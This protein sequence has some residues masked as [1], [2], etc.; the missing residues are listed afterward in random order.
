[1]PSPPP[2]PS[3]ASSRSASPTPTL[4]DPP[5]PTRRSR[6]ARNALYLDKSSLHKQSLSPASSP[7]YSGQH[8]PRSPL[9]PTT[10]IASSR[11]TSDSLDSIWDIDFERHWE[12][13][14]REEAIR[15]A[16]LKGTVPYLT[17]GRYEEEMERVRKE[18][19]ASRHVH[20]FS[21]NGS[22]VSRGPSAIGKAEEIG[23]GSSDSGTSSAGIRE[24]KKKGMLE[25][26]ADNR[27]TL[28]KLMRKKRFHLIMIGLVAFDLV[29][30]MIELIVA[31]LTAG[32]VNEEIYEL[33]LES[34]KHAHDQHLTPAMF[35]CSLAPSHSREMLEN[36]IFGVNL[37]LLSIFTLDVMF[38][39]Y[40][41]GPITYATSW[42]TLLDGFVVLT[43]FV[44][45]VYFHFSKDPNAESPIALVILRLWKIFRAAHAIGHA[46][47]L[48]Y[49]EMMEKAEEGRKK[50]E[51][52]RISES[53]RLNYVRSTLVD[54]TGQD[55]DPEHV[56]ELVRS[57]IHD[58]QKKRKQEELRV[59]QELRSGGIFRC[60]SR[61]GGI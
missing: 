48:H 43:T 27:R 54:K 39:I 34:V 40:A 14:Q 8:Y 23:S 31:L 5:S 60:R 44:L 25:K 52:E 57:E 18:E 47:Q 49:T 32:C 46:L 29:I 22:A 53:I 50:L 28:R 11:K 45:D 10:S 4:V 26:I 35:A 20:G 41:F 38:A 56:E 21:E 1:M 13:R 17:F 16:Q 59:I 42:V 30:V 9:S 55:I 15:L 19:K 36:G 6:S 3:R 12:Q 61:H 37:T 58:I 24:E 33:V 7:T 51:W 2:S